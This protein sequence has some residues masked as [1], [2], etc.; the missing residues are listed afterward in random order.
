MCHWTYHSTE[1]SIAYDCRLFMITDGRARFLSEDREYMLAE[2]SIVVIKAGHTYWLQAMDEK[3]FTLYGI[4]FDLTQAHKQID[5]FIQP[6]KKSN[7]DASKILEHINLPELD[8]AIVIRGSAELA[9]RVKEMFFEYHSGLAHRE[10]RLSA[11]LTDLIIC[12]C[13]MASGGDSRRTVLVN[14]IKHCIH[15]HYREKLTNAFIAKKLGYH[16][17]Y[18]ARIFREETGTTMHNYLHDFRLMAAVQILASMPSVS[19]ESVAADCGFATAAHFTTA[20]KKKFGR[21][22]SSFRTK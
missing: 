2:G 14:E 5:T 3:S 12:A 20:F 10:K 9:G 6:G 11:M 16:P 8:E 21:L 15:E 18:L 7:F 22:P 13:R 19:V 1:Y 4:D 17:Y